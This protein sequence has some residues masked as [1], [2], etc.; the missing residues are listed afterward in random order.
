MAF[1]DAPSDDNNANLSTGPAVNLFRSLMHF[2]ASLIALM[3][4][5]LELLTTE[6][7]EEIHRAA[8]TV[9][10]GFVAL[11]AVMMGLFMAGFTI[12]LFF[13]DSYRQLAAILVTLGF[14][15]IAAIA[16]IAIRNKTRASPSPL[17]NTL[18]ELK[19]DAEQL[20]GK[21]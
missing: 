14:F 16:V 18:S 1:N 9:M 17:S 13:W 19:K 3:Q 11:V 20:R 15:A 10:L 2:F 21:L 6:L 8:H 12:V 7:Q 4:T 5:R